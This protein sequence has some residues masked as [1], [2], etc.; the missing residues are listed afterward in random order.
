M[1]HRGRSDGAD[2]LPMAIDSG[3]RGLDQSR[4]NPL[5]GISQYTQS[6][7]N[8]PAAESTGILAGDLE[9]EAY[10][11][12]AG[13]IPPSLLEQVWTVVQAYA[14]ARETRARASRVEDTLRDPEATLEERITSN[15]TAAL[16]TVINT[17]LAGAPDRGRDRPSYASIAARNIATPSRAS[18]ERT[19]RSRV[20]REVTIR[21][22]NAPPDISSRTPKDTVAAA[23][24]ARGDTNVVAARKLPS[25]DTV[26]T[27]L[28]ADKA[29]AR[30]AE[31]WVTK[32][33]GENAAL[34]PPTFAVVAKGI[35]LASI[36]NDTN[37][38]IE[39]INEA[40][41]LRVLQAK[42]QKAGR[43]GSNAKANLILRVSSIKEANRLC[44]NSLL[45][46][47]QLYD[48][49]PFD[50]GLR[51]TQCYNC[52]K[53][54]H[55]AR[56]CKSNPTCG[57]CGGATHPD[58]EGCPTERNEIPQSCVLCKGEHPAWSRNCPVAATHWARAKEGYPD[59]PLRF[60]EH[61]A[62]KPPG[63][64]SLPPPSTAQLR[65]AL[66]PKRPGRPPG[67]PNKRRASTGQS[68]TRAHA[69]TVPGRA[70]MYVNKRHGPESWTSQAGE[71]WASVTFTKTQHRIVA[72]Y[73]PPNSR[74]E[75][76]ALRALAGTAP[77]DHTLLIGDFNLHHPLWDYYGRSDRGSDYFIEEAQR[78][79]V[80]LLTPQGTVTRSAQNHRNSTL[81]LAW[82]TEAINATY[83]GTDY[84]LEGS[85]HFP[86]RVRIATIPEEP[87]PE[88][89]PGYNWKKTNP[90]NAL[91]EAAVRL[92][93]TRGTIT[94][95]E[96]LDEAVDWLMEQLE[97]I[98]RFA[99]P[100]R[101]K[102]GPYRNPWW[103]SEIT[104]ATNELK[105]ARRRA[106]RTGQLSD[107]RA[108]SEA[109]AQRDQHVK[110]A[111]RSHWRE[112]LADLPRYDI[113]KFWK[114]ERW[115]RLRSGAAATP[116]Q[117]PPLTRQDHPEPA[118]LHA[119]KTEILA[120][121]F[122]PKPW[123][124]NSDLP[125]PPPPGSPEPESGPMCPR[126]APSEISEALSK[127][128]SW[129]AP[130]E[131]G[132]PAGFLKACGK[133]FIL[134]LTE[135]VNASIAIG[136]F[137]THFRTAIVTVIPK[138]NKTPAQQRTASGWRPISLLNVIGKIIETVISQRIATTAEAKGLLP[139]GQ[140]GNRPRKSTELALAV[141]VEA[142]PRTARL[143][144]DGQISDPIEVQAGVPQ[145]SPLSPILFIL[146]VSSLYEA[147]KRA[148]GTLVVGFADDTNI[149][150]FGR[151][152]EETRARLETAWEICDNW[153]RTNGMTWE[154]D[155]AVLMHFTR[156]RAP[157]QT[158][159]QLGDLTI[160]PKESCRFLGLFLHRKLLWGPHINHLKGKL[161]RQRRALTAIAASTWGVGL[162]AARLLYTQVIRSTIGYGAGAYHTP[163][164]PGGKPR[165]IA[166]ALATEQTR[167]LRV[168][169]GAY[170][171]TPARLLETELAVP[172]LDIYLNELAA[173]F[174]SRTE[175]QNTTP[176][177]RNA[178]AAATRWI[179]RKQRR[180]PWRQPQQEVKD[181]LRSWL[182]RSQSQG[183]SLQTIQARTLSEW[184]ARWT[185]LQDEA[186]ERRGSNRL[187]PA[188]AHPPANK[189]KALHLHQGLDKHQSSM[190]IQLRTGKIGLRS[191]LFSRR[192]PDVPSPRCPCGTSEETPEHIIVFC[193]RFVE[194]RGHLTNPPRDRRELRIQLSTRKTAQP[195]AR[196]F[197]NLRLIPHYEL[198]LRIHGNRDRD[199]EAERE[200]MAQLTRNLGC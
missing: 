105:R 174:H 24:L 36:P 41:Q 17:A 82:A 52:F 137:P 75:S 129:K 158:R 44:D 173:R 9:T 25:G 84:D 184:T 156:K 87:A 3:A 32:A 136:H 163:T 69:S 188:E 102:P 85:D 12:I 42:K 193:P 135:I 45:L 167:A 98:A 198:A 140:M 171:A 77:T 60:Q 116:P 79:R 187:E 127:I 120:R 4:H 192:V 166:R 50:E 91:N 34:S 19:T 195:L 123:A 154:P 97:A 119:D 161:D 76:P 5:A 40:N 15:V 23:N 149:L 18:P 106:Q 54:G 101:R 27:F 159:I 35:R 115:A 160:T 152:T 2:A 86:Q 55:L 170:K 153:A 56:N 157:D 125:P 200:L 130:G 176:L 61:V 182:P 22:R 47:A 121:K 185:R 113:S 128:R 93:W 114:M 147:L 145:G 74:G 48:C 81:D 99:T 64:W 83:E 189:K 179:R 180:G 183:A 155:K 29:Q 139:S 68:P 39:E 59:R 8:E 112:L 181:W 108:L 175:R 150:A 57:R 13:I 10:N 71:D 111:Q 133:P 20:E 131:D 146:F 62:P 11:A 46:D 126:I 194:Q 142:V 49:E 172:P 177:I 70:V 72:L 96:A 89:D 186:R 14:G 144:F 30:C 21:T 66:A 191:F 16:T 38:L 138:A 165:G 80:G 141:V 143:R 107:W 51:P 197:L 164:S 1:T 65:R 73:N 43:P 103:N 67:S 178:S 90:Q 88:P 122:F 199:A 151:N 58:G 95:A 7:S 92:Q 196:W 118:T 132:I 124:D 117:L 148:P 63:G 190:L 53:F 28:T 37:K 26:L 31:D 100:K 94:S 168:V 104:E 134:V 169:S 110:N 162:E 78:L 109:R 6:E 33:F